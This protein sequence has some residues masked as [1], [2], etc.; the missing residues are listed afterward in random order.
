MVL[1]LHFLIQQL[2]ADEPAALFH[3][4]FA[5]SL[6]ERLRT[7]F[8]IM[9]GTSTPNRG[10]LPQYKLIHVQC[11]EKVPERRFPL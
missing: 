1:T 2:A 8:F 5:L 7:T 11:T 4:L 6:E 10:N 9:T 3:T